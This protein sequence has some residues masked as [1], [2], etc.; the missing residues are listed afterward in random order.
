MIQHKIGQNIWI[1]IQAAL[2]AMVRKKTKN[3][4]RQK[5]EDEW[6]AS[7]E[8]ELSLTAQQYGLDI[9]EDSQDAGVKDV[10]LT[11]SG[12]KRKRLGSSKKEQEDVKDSKGDLS[13]LEELFGGK[14]EVR[15]CCFPA[16]RWVN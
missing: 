10:T 9:S 4:Q 11:E 15:S 2:F 13:R 1:H 5:K 14:F 8:K 12:K 16:C 3:R 6:V 7:V